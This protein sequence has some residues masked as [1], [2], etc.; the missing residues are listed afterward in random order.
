MMRSSATDYRIRF[1]QGPRDPEGCSLTCK[2]TLSAPPQGEEQ[3][4]GGSTYSQQIPCYDRP[5]GQTA[6]CE[7]VFSSDSVFFASPTKSIWPQSMQMSAS[8]QISANLLVRNLAL[9]GR[10]DTLPVDRIE[11]GSRLVPPHLRHFFSS[12]IMQ[13]FI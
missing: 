4:R 12:F 7:G 2:I 3:E 10:K 13:P 11:P 6:S 8:T 1:L 5:A 9:L